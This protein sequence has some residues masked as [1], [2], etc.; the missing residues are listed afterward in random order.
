VVV[1]DNW[2]TEVTSSG[3]WE[4]TGKI[5]VPEFAGG[6]LH[7]FTVPKAALRSRI[8]VMSPQSSRPGLARIKPGNLEV[9]RRYT[10]GWVVYLRAR[11]SSGIPE[12][13]SGKNRP[14][15]TGFWHVL[16]HARTMGCGIYCQIIAT[17]QEGITH[18][19]D[20]QYAL[21]A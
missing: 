7:S 6:G 18:G 16:S 3:G 12:A 10:S 20:K 17:Y 8:W 5:G 14:H 1:E 9:Y 21:S 2:F 11:V 19:L 4:T 13:A 15:P